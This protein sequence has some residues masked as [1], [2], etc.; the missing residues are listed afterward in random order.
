[1]PHVNVQLWCVIQVVI[2]DTTLSLLTL[3]LVC[4][5]VLMLLDLWMLMLLD[6]WM[7]IKW[8]NQF[9]SLS[10]LVFYIETSPVHQGFVDDW[11]RLWQCEQMISNNLCIIKYLFLN[12]QMTEYENMIHFFFFLIFFCPLLNAG[13]RFA[14]CFLFL[15][16]LFFP[17]IQL[18]RSISHFNCL[19]P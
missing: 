12:K 14:P 6:L 17:L 19:V 13:F 5:C 1:M 4:D 7:M 15:N 8:T 11:N 16:V 3:L 10:F 18:S 9:I 2:F